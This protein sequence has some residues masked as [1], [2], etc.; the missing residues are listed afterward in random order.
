MYGVTSDEKEVR[1]ALD[2]M[3]DKPGEASGILVELGRK[4]QNLFRFEK[5]LEGEEDGSKPG[6][7]TV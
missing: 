2:A 3:W 6:A 4:N 5:M 7:I 1:E